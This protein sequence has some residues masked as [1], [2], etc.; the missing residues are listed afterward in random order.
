MK[1]VLTLGWFLAI[2]ASLALPAQAR[3]IAASPDFGPALVWI[4][5]VVALCIA[6]AVIARGGRKTVPDRATLREQLRTSLSAPLTPITAPIRLGESEVCYYRGDATAFSV[7][8][9]R[10]Y[11][12]VYGGPSVRVARGLYLRTGASRGQSQSVPGM[13]SDGPG[14]LYITNL[15][16][17]FIG[18]LKSTTVDFAKVAQVSGVP[19]G[20][21]LDVLG[22]TPVE[23]QTGNAI[24]YLTTERI[25]RG[26]LDA[27]TPE[28]VDAACEGFD[29]S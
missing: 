20:V 26:L 17:I 16:F 27:L 28:Q 15:R 14:T 13:A 1:R 6:I 18:N 23:F 8:V 5:V 11:G 29:A 4:V 21:R 19:G 10:Q 2:M 24:A 3:T 22:G 9:S 25:Q 12:G 7:H